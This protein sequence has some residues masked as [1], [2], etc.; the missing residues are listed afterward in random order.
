[1]DTREI[2]LKIED[3]MEQQCKKESNVFGYGIW[4]HHIKVVVKFGKLLA[5]RLGA[6]KEIV[7]IAALLHDYAG[8]KDYK[9][10]EQHHLFSAYEA[11]NILK[12]MNYPEE[13]I[14]K[15]KECI[16]SHRGSI[17]IEKKTKESICVASA[18][19]M[20][21][22][23]QVPSLLHMVYV[24]KK[25]NIDE[26]MEWVNKKISRSW[27]KLSPEAKEI[28]KHKYESARSILEITR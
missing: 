22:I 15:I 2:I 17:E 9:L 4:T 1:M 27:N 28:I 24:N 18:D 11:E 20:A 19:A 8:I 16:I 12:N 5:C 26:G 21:H 7:E 13:K 25:M 23:D 3:I 10:F 14:I 6:D